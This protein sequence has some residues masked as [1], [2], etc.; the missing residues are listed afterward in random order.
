FYVQFAFFQ[1]LLAFL[2]SLVRSFLLFE[3][4]DFELHNL[5]FKLSAP[6]CQA[7]ELV[8]NFDEKNKV[9]IKISS[10]VAEYL[11]Q[12]NG[13]YIGLF[14]RTLAA[15]EE[16]F[17]NR[18]K[19]AEVK[20]SEIAEYLLSFKFLNFISTFRA[21]PQLDNLMENVTVTLLE[22]TVY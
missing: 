18:G 2:P 13:G 16:K 3:Q 4:L 9:G 1:L 21:A 15:I 10:K 19:Y 14:S 6:S 22:H 8:E 5:E 17:K 12:M 7:R 11:M 20:E